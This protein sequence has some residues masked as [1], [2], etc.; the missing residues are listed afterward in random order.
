[1]L[2]VVLQLLLGEFAADETPVVEVVSKLID[3]RAKFPA[4]DWVSKYS[5]DVVDGVGGIGRGLLLGGISY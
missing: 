5:L 2:D 3:E 1:V 4:S